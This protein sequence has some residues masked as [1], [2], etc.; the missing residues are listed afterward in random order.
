MTPVT[1]MN[2]PK[3]I[4]RES[5]LAAAVFASSFRWAPMYWDTSASPPEL[6]PKAN[7]MRKKMTGPA[8]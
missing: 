3:T 4:D 5:V 6:N 2:S 7:A 8:I 1:M